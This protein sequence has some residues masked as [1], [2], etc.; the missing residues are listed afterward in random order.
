MIMEENTPLRI[1]EMDLTYIGIGGIPMWA[2]DGRP[3][4]GIVVGTDDD[5]T[6]VFERD[7]V[8]GI[9]EG[10]FRYYHPNGR[11]EEEYQVEDGHTVPGTKRCWNKNGEW[12]SEE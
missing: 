4:T 1:N 5:G 3:F 9:E 2:Y 6:L 8:N 10:W 7:C 12:L 11:L